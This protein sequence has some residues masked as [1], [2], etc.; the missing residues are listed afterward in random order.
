MAQPSRSNDKPE[1]SAGPAARGKKA[2]G[3]SKSAPKKSGMP[4]LMAPRKPADTGRRIDEKSPIWRR[5]V[6]YLVNVRTE[7]GKVIWP[8]RPEII[9]STLI[10]IATL[11]VVGLYIFVLDFVFEGFIKLITGGFVPLG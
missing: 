11:V 9:Q 8:K 5:F 10:V 7:L 2:K 3:S 4:S 1:K 6:N